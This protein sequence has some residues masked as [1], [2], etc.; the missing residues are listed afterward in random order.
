MGTISPGQIAFNYPDQHYGSHEKYLAACA[1][2]L[3]YEYRAIIDAG[4][5]F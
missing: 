3:S 4:F 5:N 2:A 1:D